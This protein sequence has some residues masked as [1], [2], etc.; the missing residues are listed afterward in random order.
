MTRAEDNARI[1]K[2]RNE[3]GKLAL[4]SFRMAFNFTINRGM[5]DITPNMLINREYEID[6]DVYLTSKGKNLQ[7]EFVWTSLQKEQ[8]I[9]SIL[10]GVTIPPITIILY[11]RKLIKV[12]D[13]KQRLSTIIS[14]VKNEFPIIHEGNEWYYNDLTEESK[15]AIQNGIRADIGYE[16]SDKLISDDDLI[17]WYWQ[18][19]FAGTPQDVNHI[20][21]LRS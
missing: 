6:Y 15:G 17:T 5:G 14:F 4:H 3:P 20:A 9:I 8:L 16:Y 13:G 18:I 12:I 7:R 21:N 1:E 10:K 2:Y 11:D 19:N